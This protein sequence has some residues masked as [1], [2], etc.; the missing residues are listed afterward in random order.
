M[1][2]EDKK[3]QGLNIVFT[4]KCDDIAK[5]EVTTNV[6]MTDHKD[7]DVPE[8]LNHELA[9]HLAQSVV[10]FLDKKAAEHPKKG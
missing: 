8:D 2:T 10:G 9:K 6:R 1:S 3:Q 5:G 7:N 4:F